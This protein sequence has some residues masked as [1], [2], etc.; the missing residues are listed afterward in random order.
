MNSKDLQISLYHLE[1]IVKD[2][3]NILNSLEDLELSDVL[4]RPIFGYLSIRTCAFYDELNHHFIKKAKSEDTRF[5]KAIEIKN[6]IE[7]VRNKYCPDL[8]KIRNT[9]LAH[10]FRIKTTIYESIFGY[11]TEYR[12]PDSSANYGFN[13]VLIDLMLSSI[14]FLYPEIYSEVHKISK[15]PKETILKKVN[16]RLIYKEVEIE[17][18]KIVDSI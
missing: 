13:L 1:L 8:Y 12:I 18:Q 7:S 15:F 14:K 10:N 11:S 17:V 4:L 3:S 16:Y 6:Y 5:L 9:I 2:S